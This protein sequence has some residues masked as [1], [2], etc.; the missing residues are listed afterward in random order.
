M[1]LAHHDGAAL[2][3][4]CS[5]PWKKMS[6]GFVGFSDGW[7]DLS[8]HFQMQ[9]TYPAR[10]ERQ[11]RLHRRNRPCRLQL[12]NVGGGIQTVM[13]HDAIDRFVLWFL[14]VP[15][16]T[17]NS[18]TPP[19]ASRDLR[20]AMLRECSA[21]TASARRNVK[22]NI[23]LSPLRRPLRRLRSLWQIDHRGGLTVRCGSGWAQT[24]T[25]PLVHWSGDR[26]RARFVLRYPEDWFVSFGV[27]NAAAT[28]L[29]IANAFPSAEIGKIQTV[30]V[31]CESVAPPSPRR[32]L[33]RGSQLSGTAGLELSVPELAL[34]LV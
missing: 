25:L 19:T 6:V 16:A 11:H 18:S 14:N 33:P 27:E 22:P 21:L 2:A 9:W 30:G 7:Q 26:F 20:G 3:F 10:R 8:Q 32:V 24:A 29:T 31:T 15:G 12:T 5:A 23:P 34:I 1:F 13:M 28:T 4:G 17:A